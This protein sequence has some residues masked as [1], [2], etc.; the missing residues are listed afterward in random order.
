MDN[1][2]VVKLYEE[3]K[4]R[5][6]K[7]LSSFKIKGELNPDIWENDFSIK[8]VVKRGL[9]EIAQEYYNTLGINAE[10]QDI[11]LTGSLSN[12]NYSRY[13]DFDL[14]IVIDFRDVNTDTELVK[15]Y[16]DAT[17]QIW[18]NTHDIK[19]KGFDV[20]VYVQDINERHDSSGIYS[21]LKDRW[22][23]RP[24]KKNFIKPS[25]ELIRVKVID[26]MKQIDDI[27]SEVKSMKSIKE[28]YDSINAK[29]TKVWDKIKKWRKEALET[30]Q[31]EFGIGNLIFK[32]LRRNKY[33]EK[34]I[35]IKTKIY[36]K[37]LTIK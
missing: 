11:V 6:L 7:P 14:H 25:D 10:I 9:L 23:V 2:I 12:Y 8:S 30:E 29:I 32:F 15:K 4:K 33:I 16:V 35:Q 19:I 27:E 22:I 36:D 3:F 34:L 24:V 5:D 28:E 18:N 17:R 13:S 21:L 37:K 26:L 1:K 20:E 31:N